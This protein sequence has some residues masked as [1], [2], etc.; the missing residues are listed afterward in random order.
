MKNS[1]IAV[2]AT[3]IV[4]ISTTLNSQTTQLN[5]KQ[6]GKT[7]Y[8][9]TISLSDAKG[10][11]GNTPDQFIASEYIYFVIQPNEK[12]ER[13][14]FKEGDVKDEIASIAL[15]QEK[16]VE[17]AQNIQSI[18]EDGKIT[19]ILL[20]YAK[21]DVK[22]WLSFVFRSA[23]D[24]SEPIYL[25]ETYY[26]DFKLFATKYNTLLKLEKEKKFEEMLSTSKE[27]LNESKGSDFFKHLSFYDALID[28]L[29][30]K[31][32]KEP[33]TQ[34]KN[35]FQNTE[36]KFSKSYD[37]NDLE[38]LDEII[39][40]SEV[41]F[42]KVETFCELDFPKKTESLN[43]VKSIR[44][45]FAKQ[46][47]FQFD[48]FAAKKIQLLETGTFDQY[49]FRLF[50][51][52]LQKIIL[53]NSGFT[54]VKSNLSL[55]KSLSKDD[56]LNLETSGWKQDFDDMIFGLTFKSDSLP[57]TYIFNEKIINNLEQQRANQ[58][59]P[60]YELFISANSAV[61]GDN[62]FV[63]K[64]QECINLSADYEDIEQMELMKISYDLTS[65]DLSESSRNNLN[66]GKKN[67]S[68]GKW[69]EADFNFELAIRQNSQFAPAWF[70]LGYA[71]SKL[72]ELFSAQSRIDQSLQ[73]LPDYITPKLFSFN[74]LKEQG[75]FAKILQLSK[76]AV[77]IN[78]AYL[79]HLWKAEA[80]FML[81]QYNEAVEE[82]KS[83]CLPL[84]QN[85]EAV[86]FLLGDIY[87]A[88][89]KIDLA[90][91]AY[92]KTQQI[93]PFESALFNEKMGL[94]P[95]VK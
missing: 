21:K 45:D 92:Q 53:Q 19:R 79:I 24:S 6:K 42:R 84:N 49:Q 81:K 52:L 20:T 32:I 12:S 55:N 39:D 82:I 69:K 63:E 1:T 70:Y 85:H 76:T 3:V 38:E 35:K 28:S 95:V 16:K 59:K 47:K 51:N 68:V 90:K 9:L 30:F 37:I 72:L 5:Y 4:L 87:V 33:I 60:Y 44:E 18:E 14:Y 10:I 23:I 22:L 2:F 11:V 83:G 36:S 74:L 80:H 66:A 40:E 8:S 54:S 26:D 88:L 7:T 89:K 77:A 64:I 41:F 75:D 29:P 91:E 34:L 71:E 48:N 46:R 57:T 94:L 86:Y 31:A 25:N 93:N 50:V 61:N 73:L 65:E 17:F 62:S 58:P 13:A 67:L 27:V 43:L 78:N 56:E 15:F